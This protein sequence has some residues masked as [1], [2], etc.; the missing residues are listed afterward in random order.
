[1]QIA[2]YVLKTLTVKRRGNFVNYS[3]HF[4]QLVAFILVI[5]VIGSQALPHNNEVETGD[6]ED[7]GLNDVELVEMEKFEANLRTENDAKCSQ[8][9]GKAKKLFGNCMK[10][11]KKITYYK[12][13]S[14][15][16]C[17]FYLI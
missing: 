14:I 5:G 15:T 16:R 2:G 17:I 9:Y 4:F 1:M 8:Q 13:Y 6:L 3:F 10:K 12:Y 7:L 11:G